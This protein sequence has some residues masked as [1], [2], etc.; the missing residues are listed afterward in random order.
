MV[1]D[2]DADLSGQKWLR[3]LINPQH[4][5]DFT[6]T[7]RWAMHR[8]TTTQNIWSH[9]FHTDT[10][11]S[12]SH[13]PYIQIIAETSHQ[14][15]H[16]MAAFYKTSSQLKQLVDNYL[17]SWWEHKPTVLATDIH[18]NNEYLKK[19]IKL[20]IRSHILSVDIT[21]TSETFTDKYKH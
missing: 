6:S 9:T 19:N 5:C 16:T 7:A 4:K 1:S 20:V 12:T 18:N 3:H 10:H 13:L 2:D 15:R 17:Q 11:T 14:N 8:Y 21:M